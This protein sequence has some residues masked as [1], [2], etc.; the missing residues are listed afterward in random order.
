MLSELFQNGSERGVKPS[1]THAMRIGKKKPVV[2][3]LFLK[4]P[5]E[6]IHL[7]QSSSKA[8]ERKGKMVSLCL[9]TI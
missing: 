4:T 1:I 7:N 8:E 6:F 5:G 3:N 9:A 2:E